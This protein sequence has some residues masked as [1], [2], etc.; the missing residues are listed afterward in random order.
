MPLGM[1]P[2]TINKICWAIEDKFSNF[3]IDD[4]CE[5]DYSIMKCNVNYSKQ[6]FNKIK[7]IYE[8]YKKELSTYMQLAK[9]LKEL[10]QKI[11]NYRN[12]Y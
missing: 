12:T 8:S 9:I 10:N 5:F 1:S 7:K 6:L 4:D 11:S 2:C 3:K